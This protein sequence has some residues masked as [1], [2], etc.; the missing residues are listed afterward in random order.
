MNTA[1]WTIDN[2]GVINHLFLVCG[3]PIHVRSDNGPVF[4]AFALQQWLRDHHC[5]TLHIKS[6]SSPWENPFIESF[7]G[8]FRAEC[9]NRWLF[10]DGRE[11]QTIIEQWRQEYNHHRPHSSLGYVPPAAFAQITLTDTG[12]QSQLNRLNRIDTKIGP[13]LI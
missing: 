8:T 7:N 2:S 6:G 9:L 4:I 12:I 1:I 11:A 3:A 10:A 5:H 13:M